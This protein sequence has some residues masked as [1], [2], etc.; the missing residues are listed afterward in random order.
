MTVRRFTPFG[1]SPLER[2]LARN[3]DGDIDPAATAERLR[4]A[5]DDRWVTVCRDWLRRGLF[6]FVLE[7]FGDDLRW[8][9]EES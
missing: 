3:E 2:A 5:A 6:A 8:E 7:H 4:Q 1:Y 9:W